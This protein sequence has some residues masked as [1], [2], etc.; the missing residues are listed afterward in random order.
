MERVL[1]NSGLAP[2]SVDGTRFCY[3]NPLARRDGVPLLNND[4]PRRW[5]THKCY[6][7]PP[8]VARTLAKVHS[9]AYAVSDG[10][11]WV[12]LYGGSTL[13]THLPDG[14]AVALAQA[15]DY[16]WAG[17]VTLTVRAAPAGPMA[18][19]LRI[20]GWADGATVRA[21]GEPLEVPAKAGAY[22]E[23]RRRWAAGD[24]LTLDLPMEPVLVEANPLVET[25]VDQVAV[26]RGPV[27]Y[28]LESI[29]LP[30][31]VALADVRLPRRP[32]WT[33]RHEPGLLAGVTV[34]ET[35]AVAV[36]GGGPW[37]GLYR[38]L[39]EGEPRPVRL[40]LIP[41]YA[42]NNRDET[43]MTVWLPLL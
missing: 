31:G 34:L 29:D 20:P 26:M 28:C 10:A 37:Q 33:V 23:V 41:Y 3:C 15:T 22:A 2:M 18:V 42:W 38:R 21:N 5:F 30:A 16:P 17:K 1:Y 6:C 13:A 24:V 35:E 40:R 9:W 11:V 19:M 25:E 32:R 43:E 36:P 12:N 7:C 39:P 14:S 27:V 4:T 8:S